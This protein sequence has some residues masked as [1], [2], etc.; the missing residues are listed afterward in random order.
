MSGI[1]F[2]IFASCV[3]LNTYFTSFTQAWC[4]ERKPAAVC[5]AMYDIEHKNKQTNKQTNKQKQKQKNTGD[6]KRERERGQNLKRQHFNYP[7]RPTASNRGYTD[8]L[9]VPTLTL[10]KMPRFQ[11]D[12]LSSSKHVKI[13]WLLFHISFPDYI[14][15]HTPQWTCWR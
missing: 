12:F 9:T 15:Q 10:E 3:P 4:R 6:K 7:K 14:W 5:T 1:L 2:F 11:S 8:T 13:D